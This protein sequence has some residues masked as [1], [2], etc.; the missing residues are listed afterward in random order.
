L[1]RIP[2]VKALPP[3]RAPE[4]QEIGRTFL[5]KGH[6]IGTCSYFDADS[7]TE[8]NTAC[9]VADHLV[10]LV[11]EGVRKLSVGKPEDDCDITPV[12]GPSSAA[13]IQGLVEDAQEKGAGGSVHFFK[14]VLFFLSAEFTTTHYIASIVC[15]FKYLWPTLG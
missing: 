12:I 15:K 14:G 2:P 1:V 3:R 10:A 5:F 9:Q 13:F 11:A 8:K 4:S 7:A 6:K